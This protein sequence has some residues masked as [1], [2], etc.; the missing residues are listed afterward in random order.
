M[1]Q[2]D[3]EILNEKVPGYMDVIRT[4]YK[5]WMDNLDGG[6][7]EDVVPSLADYSVHLDDD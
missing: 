5:K 6:I 1:S 7:L 3:R 4:E 2:A